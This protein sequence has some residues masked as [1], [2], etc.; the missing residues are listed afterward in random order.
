MNR[1][2]DTARQAGSG[3]R[4]PGLQRRRCHLPPARDPSADAVTG[5]QGYQSGTLTDTFLTWIYEAVG[6]VVSYRFDRR[7]KVTVS[8]RIRGHG[9]LWHVVDVEFRST[10][11]EAH[12]RATEILKNWRSG[13]YAE[14]DPLG[15]SE[16]KRRRVASKRAAGEAV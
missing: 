16:I 9:K 12:D 1:G 11:D 13:Q 4:D 10:L 5:L 7:W 15:R 2:P 6:Y 8:R 3:G 14:A